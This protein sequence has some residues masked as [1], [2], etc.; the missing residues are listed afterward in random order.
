[1]V[2][3]EGPLS[4]AYD[5]AL[6]YLEALP[7]RRVG[8]RATAAELHEA[9]GGPLPTGATD[10]REVV[11]HLAKGV[12]DG[13][14]PSG[15][16]RFFGFVFGG[17]TPASLAADWLTTVWDQNAGLYAASPAA[18]VVED[19]TARWLVELFGLPA[20]TS[21]GFV[22]GAQMAN[23]T[24]LAA[25]R[26]EVLRRAGWD[27]ERQGLSGSPRIRVLAG[28]ER[29]DT[30]DRALRFLGLG[31]DCIE[32]IPVDDQGRMRADAL[33]EA[34]R[35]NGRGAVP[36][37]VCAQAGNVNTGAFDPVAEVCETAHAHGAWVHVDGAFG[38][39]A[40]VSS[41]LRQL[42][43]GVE[44]AD[45]WATD[46]HKWLNVPYDSGLVFCAH[47]EPHRAAMSI[48]AAYLIQD[49]NGE[50][51]SLDYN[52]EFSRRARGIPV[53]AAI[54]ALGREGI[55]E[56]V[57]RCHAMAERFADHLRTADVE[58]LNDVVLNQ[59]LVRFDDDDA[60]TRRVVTEVQNEGT[61]WM[62]GT[63]WQGKAAMRISVSNW[64]TGPEDIDR[65]AEAVLRCLQQV[66]G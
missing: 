19:V 16:G 30:I 5:R 32:P 45:S 24:A 59:V 60:I 18:A 40:R 6:T 17:A 63:T 34:L 7:E 51:D 4:E 53:Y 33:A 54:R 11:E 42:V 8:P 61:C 14:L 35:E 48:R 46:A 66:R 27:V 10:P 29:H 49:E 23:F 38:I 3:W 44:Q 1:M 12:D 36:T 15:S 31:T 9:L 43:D 13:L 52:P 50:R 21:V 26:H 56:I 25:A 20:G 47:P 22:T 2:D 41:G 62:S 39:W 37:I 57:D 55:A 58:I 64:T 28:A 65:S